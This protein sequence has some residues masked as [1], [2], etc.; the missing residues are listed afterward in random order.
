MKSSWESEKGRLV[1]EIKEM[2]KKE[3]EVAIN[4]TKKKQWV[5]LISINMMHAISVIFILA[6]RR[7]V[8]GWGGEYCIFIELLLF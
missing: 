2:G 6:K 3:K 1:D 5:N 4:E 8:F 7:A